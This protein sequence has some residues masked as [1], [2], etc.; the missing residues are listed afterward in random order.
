MARKRA[1][2]TSKKAKGKRKKAK[3]RS[4]TPYTEF[5]LSIVTEKC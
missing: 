4:S 2:G 5:F 3:V 1:K